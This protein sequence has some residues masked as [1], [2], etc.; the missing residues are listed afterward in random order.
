MHVERVRVQIICCKQTTT[1]PS[2]FKHVITRQR[3]QM[4]THDKKGETHEIATLPVRW[5]D[6][7]TCS[8]VRSLPSRCIT[9]FCVP[10]IR[11]SF[12][13][14]QINVG[15][16]IADLIKR[17]CVP[18]AVRSSASSWWIAADVSVPETTTTTN[19]K[20]STSETRFLLKR[21]AH[22]IHRCAVMHVCVDLEQHPGKLLP[23]NEARG[24]IDKTARSCLANVVE[25][26]MRHELLSLLRARPCKRTNERQNMSKWAT[27]ST[28]DNEP[29]PSIDSAS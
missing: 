21:L 1:K 19:K 2:Q 3:N 22:L 13:R 15:W 9:T 4:K 8:S 14:R 7:N 20:K 25:V 16:I 27:K 11:D 12:P 18:I 24:R 10:S 26:A 6:S 23:T 17:F 28:K 29:S 5:S